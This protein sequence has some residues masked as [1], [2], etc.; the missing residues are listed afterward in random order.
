MSLFPSVHLPSGEQTVQRITYL[1]EVRNRLLRPL[2]S[3]YGS[4]TSSGF[5]STAD[6]KFDR[7]LFLNDIYF[8]PLDAAHLLFSTNADSGQAKY[9]A[10]C[11]MDF[12][13]G[14]QQYDTFVVRDTDGYSSG[15]ML[16]PWFAPVGSSTSRSAVLSQTDAVPVRSCWGGM[17][18]FNAS[19]FQTRDASSAFSMSADYELLHFRS[20]GEL[21]WEA[22]ECCLV[23][24]DIEE[25]YGMPN[26]DDGTGVFVNPYVRVA[27]SQSTWFWLPILRRF[28]RMFQY[29]QYI[30]SKMVYPEF[31]PRRLHEPGE[32]VDEMI[33]QPA[34]PTV[35]ES[36][37]QFNVVH[38]QASP[39]GFC[40]QR[41]LFVMK[42]DL[43][44][45]N[46]DSTGINWEKITLPR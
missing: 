16:Y 18:A 30:L 14:A 29:L 7:I 22:A 4:N 9:R 41:R 25:Q 20:S 3:T 26:A 45:A 2:D 33:W 19:L 39:G 17:A 5:T 36:G 8:D 32:L 23:F 44:T 1:A 38:R 6:T 34:S 21:F 10:A 15:F 40:G 27:Y 46:T 13:R 37:G 28:E 11:A 43:E 31:N 35:P 42:H 24:A 12:I